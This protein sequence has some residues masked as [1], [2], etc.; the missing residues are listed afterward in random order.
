M[1]ILLREKG[2]YRETMETEEDPNAAIEKIKWHNKRDE[3]YGLLCGRP[4]L[5][6]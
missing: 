6:S 4:P 3:A 1:E 5:P 2:I